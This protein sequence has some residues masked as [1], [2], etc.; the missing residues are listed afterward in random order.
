MPQDSSLPF[1]EKRLL[2][3][4]IYS[5][6][7]GKDVPSAAKQLAPFLKPSFAGDGI[8]ISGL[9]TNLDALWPTRAAPGSSMC[10]RIPPIGGQIHRHDILVAQD[11]RS[12]PEFQLRALF[13]D[14][15][16]V[17]ARAGLHR[18]RNPHQ[19]RCL[20]RRFGRRHPSLRRWAIHCIR[21]QPY[22]ANLGMVA[23]W[24]RVRSRPAANT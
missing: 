6:E 18:F 2:F 8:N 12:Y 14:G 20:D 15:D 23:N 13:A 4:V 21:L 16:R 24:N 10:S 7:K 11:Q 1:R 9:P 22:P 19:R 5:L 17:G 3:Q